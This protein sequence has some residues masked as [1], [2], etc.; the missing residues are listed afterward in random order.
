MTQKRI[1]TFGEHGRKVRVFKDE[2]RYTVSSRSLGVTK[3]YSGEGAKDK[4]LGFAR[5]LSAEGVGPKVSGLTVGVLWGRFTQSSDWASLRPRTRE[6]YADH[7]DYFTGSVPDDT[8]A[9]EVI[10]PTL[11]A[12]AKALLETKRPR[13]P[14]GMA[15]SS[16][17][18]IVRTVKV[19]FAW[20]ER[21]M[22][23]PRNRI[24]AYR[25]KVSRDQQ[26]VSPAEYT[27]EETRRILAALSFDRLDQRTAFV[28]LTLISQQG[29]RG[30]A[31]L[32]LRWED[33]D[34]T[35]D[36]LQM[37]PEWDKMGKA[38]SSPMRDATRA[39]LGRLWDANDQP[40]T[41]WVFPS[42]HS[43]SE[44]RPYTL[45]GLEKTLVAAEQRAGV[46]HL[47][48]RGVHGFRR[49]VAGDVYDKTGSAE[50]AMEAIGDSVGQ[51]VKYL[52]TRKGRVA[53]SLRALDRE[54]KAG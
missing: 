47:K 22:L 35:E 25:L 53:Q 11:D 9:D 27:A 45:V 40:A 29:I 4:A 50:Q 15:L 42:R 38:W 18:R 8:P 52:K 23:I 43:R 6:L 2:G 1:A 7:W 21:N 51:A 36:V 13:A 32:H 28:A 41:G 33:V 10:P 34:W 26:E 17:R 44:G 12:T 3:S 37:R 54:E 16:V 30:N 49:G 46:P 20:G 14:D 39:V 48:G 5:R 31:A 24:Y 19:V